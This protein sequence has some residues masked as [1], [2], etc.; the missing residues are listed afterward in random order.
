MCS[1]TQQF[2]PPLGLIAAPDVYY[3]GEYRCGG[4]LVRVDLRNGGDLSGRLGELCSTNNAVGLARLL[5]RSGVD[6]VWFLD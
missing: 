1:H 6:G 2:F 3:Y 5:E 4:R